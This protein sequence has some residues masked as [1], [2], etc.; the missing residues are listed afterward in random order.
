VPTVVARALHLTLDEEGRPEAVASAISAKRLLLVLDNCEHLL[1]AAAELAALLLSSAPGV[2]LLVTSQEPLKV[3]G[4]HVF[5]LPAMTLPAQASLEHALE[6]DAVTLFATRAAAADPSFKLTPANIAAVIDIC[7]RLDGIA[8]AI[9]FGAARVRL[10]GVEGLQAKLNHRFQILTTGSR[11]ALPRHQTLRAAMEWSHA[12]LTEAEQRAFRRLGVF[13]GSFSLEAAEQVVA[14]SPD[15]RW[16]VLDLLG[17]LVDK[18]L[19]VAQPGAHLRYRLLETSRAFA[20]EQLA[21][22]SELD[23]TCLRH[24]EAMADLFA[25]SCE[26]EHTSTMPALLAKYVPDLDNARAALD[27]LGSRPE[28]ALVH[29]ALAGAMGWLWI[30][31]ALR[32][33]GMR[34]TSEAAAH[35]PAG[36]PPPLEARLRIRL[37]RVSFPLGNAEL[38]AGTQRAVDILRDAGRPEALYLALVQAGTTHVRAGLAAQAEQFMSQAHALLDTAWPP[39]LRIE[40]FAARGIMLGDAGRAAESLPNFEQVLALARQCGDPR[41]VLRAM[42][43]IEQV[44]VFFG[45]YTRAVALGQEMVEMLTA[46]Q[47]L[48]GGFENLIISNLGVAHLLAGNI[49][50][51]VR[52][53]RESYGSV[54]RAGRAY[55]LLD[56]CALLAL[57]RGRKED[58]AR[59]MGRSIARFQQVAGKRQFVEQQIHDGVLADLQRALPAESLERLLAQGAALD[60]EDALQLALRD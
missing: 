59:I 43:N 1:A 41:R 13:V 52:L 38:V 22:T 18:S 10:L 17:S 50:E 6:S 60:D 45:D 3:Q 33:E 48:R 54:Q 37:A 23:R 58:A 29:V 5:R 16:E 11:L 20:L 51:S 2:H 21:S 36:T 30:D 34:R 57:K 9:E 26:E 12:L 27:W 55:E 25:R 24:A 14:D 19:V 31:A 7:R 44:C 28:H 49:D 39:A 40:Y 53:A 32:P 56:S 4:E 15:S 46:D 42:I 35:I 8:L 47:S